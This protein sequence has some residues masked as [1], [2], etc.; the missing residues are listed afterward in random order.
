MRIYS[1]TNVF[2]VVFTVIVVVV[3]VVICLCTCF[4]CVHF[5][6]LIYAF[7]YARAP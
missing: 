1:H 6:G 7:Q 5:G 3:D 2:S 4:R